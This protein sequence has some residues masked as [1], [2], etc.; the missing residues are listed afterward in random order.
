[1]VRKIHICT[2]QYIICYM[3]YQMEYSKNPWNT[4]LVRLIWIYL[5]FYPHFKFQ[6]KKPIYGSNVILFESRDS[7]YYYSN[8]NNKDVILY[9][10]SR[11]FYPKYFACELPIVYMNYLVIHRYIFYINRTKTVLIVMYITDNKM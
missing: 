10:V 7:T 11:G 6:L 3:A 5:S 9:L 2:H 4:I 8:W 1:M